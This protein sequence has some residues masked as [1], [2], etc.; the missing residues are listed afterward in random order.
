MGCHAVLLGGWLIYWTGFTVYVTWRAFAGE[1]VKVALALLW[2]SWAIVVV[3]GAFYFYATTTFT[4]LPEELVVEQRLG[5]YRRRRTIKRSSIT[6]I[7]QIKDSDKDDN[8]HTWGLVA[9]GAKNVHLLRGQHLEKSD[10]LG[11]IVA[12]WA[13]VKYEACQ[14]R[15]Y[16]RA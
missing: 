7:R 8:R 10:W 9:E 13:G 4:F 14:D 2:G 15:S 5:P 3:G 12:Q 16:F 6:T 11:P 1:E